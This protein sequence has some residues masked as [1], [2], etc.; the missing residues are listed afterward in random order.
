LKAEGYQAGG[1]AAWLFVVRMMK[2]FDIGEPR[3]GDHE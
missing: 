2:D 3:F 1:E